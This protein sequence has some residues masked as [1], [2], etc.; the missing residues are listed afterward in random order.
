MVVG[1]GLAQPNGPA[2][3]ARGPFPNR[4]GTR[5]WW[6]P[7]R[8]GGGPAHPATTGGEG[9]G[10]SGLG[11]E[12]AAGIPLEAKTGRR[13]TGNQTSHGGEARAERNDGG[14]TGGRAMQQAG[15]SGSCTVSPWCLR[16]ME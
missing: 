4:G 5:P 1:F 2:N 3:Q 7:R 6:Q 12:G 16:R 13:L 14:G 10:E 9:G 8:G 11:H 15:W